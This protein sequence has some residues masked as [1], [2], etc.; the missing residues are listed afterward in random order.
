M[1]DINQLKREIIEPV[2]RSIEMY[3]PQALN[4]LVG[5]MAQESAL[6]KY[7]VQVGSGIAQGGYQ[8]EPSTHDDIVKNYIR[9]DLMSKLNDLG[10]RDFHSS[11][12]KYDLRYATIF[13]RLHY[14]RVPERLP[15]TVEGMARYWK[16]YYNTE[17]GKGKESEFIDNYHKY[18]K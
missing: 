11:I 4:L 10:Y 16:K 18:N 15:V 13:A 3:S 7:F 5:T 14:K 9:T 1:Y 6:G 8:M 17:R 2:L 12:L